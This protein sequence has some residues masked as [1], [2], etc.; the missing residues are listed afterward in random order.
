MKTWTKGSFFA[1]VTCAVA[2]AYWLY[3]KRRI[4]LDTVGGAA[5]PSEYELKLVQV[6]FRHGARTPLKSLPGTLQAEW[7]V[8]LLQ[9]PPHTKF[10]YTVKNLRGDPRP[11]SPLEDHYRAHKLNG[12]AFH[13]QL[14]TLGMQQ[15]YNLGERLRDVYIKKSNFLS[16]VF[17]STEVY[18]RSTNIVRT[19]ES[20]VCLLAGLFQQ[21]QEGIVTVFTS[22]AETEVLYPNYTRCDHLK[23]MTRQR[24]VQASL[25]PEIAE[26]L[27]EMYKL[28]EIPEHERINFIDIWDDMASRKAHDLARPSSVHYLMKIIEKRAVET[29]HFAYEPSNS[30]SLQLCVGQLLSILIGNIE[31]K[32]KDQDSLENLRKLHL[33]SVHDTTL[34]PFLMAL[35]IFDMKWPPYSADAILELYEHRSSKEAFVKVS[36]LGKDQLVRG[37][38][39][40]Y[41]PLRDFKKALSSYVIDEVNYEEKCNQPVNTANCF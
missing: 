32:L 35:D 16:P 11:P 17:K 15:M 20:A 19:I 23:Q 40:I 41:C 36:Y 1:T 6:L 31:N 25:L 38:S 3:E 33:Y 34:M 18:V 13:G 21:Q 7:I 27:K 28:L 24:I 30:T 2:G 4:S 9:V 26:D 12:G 8:D 22:E 37:C 5:R 29:V 10:S 39:D 14:T